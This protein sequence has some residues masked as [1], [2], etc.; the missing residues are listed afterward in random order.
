MHPSSP[1]P[2]KGYLVPPDLKKLLRARKKPVDILEIDTEGHDPEVSLFE[3]GLLVI[4][5]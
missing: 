3:R 4:L 2:T 1:V 5:I